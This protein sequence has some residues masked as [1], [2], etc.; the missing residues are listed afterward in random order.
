MYAKKAFFGLPNNDLHTSRYLNLISITKDRNALDE[1]FETL[2]FNN[3]IN[4]W[5]NYLIV[6]SNLYWGTIGNASTSEGM[7]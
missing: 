1:A 3:K 7:F 5:K 4:N 2:T 6:A